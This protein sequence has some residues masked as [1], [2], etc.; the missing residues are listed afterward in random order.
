MLSNIIIRDEAP[1][2]IE[3]IGQITVAAFATLSVSRHTEQF[4]IAALRRAR[5]LSVS[6]VAESAGELIGHIAFSPVVLSDGSA[7]WYGMGPLSV[8]PSRQRAGVGTALVQAGLA[9]LSGL[10]AAGCCLVGHPAYY[11]RFGFR[12]V[13]GLSVDG[14]PDEFFFALS[15][16]AACPQG[17]VAFHPAFFADGSSAED[18][19]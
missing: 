4:I 3:A 2:D 17:R 13:P 11:T 12:P 9:R 6:L 16:G 10:S 1:A 7:G 18:V 19:R 8:V 5:A 15:F 14:V